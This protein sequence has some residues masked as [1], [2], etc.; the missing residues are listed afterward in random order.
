MATI[1]L[2]DKVTSKK[3]VMVEKKP[4]LRASVCDSCGKVFQMKEF[5]NDQNLAELRGTFDDCAGGLGNMFFAT[6]CCF[7]CA[8]DIMN[9]GWKKM[10][11]YQPYVRIKANLV[12]CELRITSYVKN[13]EEIIADWTKSKHD[14][15]IMSNWEIKKINRKK[16]MENWEAKKINKKKKK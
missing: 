2:K 1:K 9:G 5:C 14:E 16:I 13:E 7:K 6:V 3:T 8:H 12:R 4:E 10:K 15:R 11:E